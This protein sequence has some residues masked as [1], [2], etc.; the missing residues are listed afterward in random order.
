MG[1]GRG[2]R[3]KERSGEGEGHLVEGEEWGG[4]GTLDTR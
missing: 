3:Q 1:R 2:T 4:G